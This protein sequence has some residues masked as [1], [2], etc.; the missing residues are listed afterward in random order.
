MGQTINMANIEARLTALTEDAR[1]ALNGSECIEI[2]NF[3]F[4][5]GRDQRMKRS[6]GKEYV[7]E[8]R[9][10]HGSPANHCYLIEKHSPMY[11]SREHFALDY[12]GNNRFTLID[13]NSACGT[14]VENERVGGHDSGGAID[15]KP[16]Q[17]IRVGTCNSPYL[18]RFDVDESIDEA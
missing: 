7:A 11:I 18:F 12:L 13:R 14:M 17:T 2:N 5:I 4:L 16:G 1:I 15:L 10:H 9:K 3:P 8:R 6:N